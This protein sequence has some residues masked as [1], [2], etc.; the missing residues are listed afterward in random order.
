MLLADGHCSRL[1]TDPTQNMSIFD[2]AS[3]SAQSIVNL[4]IL[5]LVVT[6]ADLP[7]RRGRAALLHLAISPAATAEPTG[8]PP[9]VY[10]S[11]PIEIAW[12]AA[13]TLI[14]FVLVLVT[15]RTL[16]EVDARRAAAAAGRQRAVRH[17]D[18]PSVVVGVRLRDVRRPDARLHHRQRAAHA[19]RAT[20][21]RRGR[22]T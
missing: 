16:W 4:A 2:P 22:S 14:V 8:E 18:R 10:G 6:G 3:P 1:L 15:T 7:R 11:K 9:Q 20:T 12:T 17:R 5:A 21:T 13:P 19:G